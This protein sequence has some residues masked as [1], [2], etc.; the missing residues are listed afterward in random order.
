MVIIVAIP[1]YY[2][3]PSY[4][5]QCEKR[6][7]TTARYI[8]LTPASSETLTTRN[9]AIAKDVEAWGWR[10]YNTNRSLPKMERWFTKYEKAAKKSNWQD[11]IWKIWQRE[12]G[13]KIAE[14]DIKRKAVAAGDTSKVG[15]V[16]HSMKSV[17]EQCLG[18]NNMSFDYDE[19]R[20]RRTEA[21]KEENRRWKLADD[22]LKVRPMV[23]LPY[24][25]SD[26]EEVVEEESVSGELRGGSGGDAG[27]DAKTTSG[28]RN[29][30]FDS[31]V[32]PRHSW[33]Y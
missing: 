30:V 14:E 24:P 29:E 11:D 16:L 17:R 23:S 10:I 18:K 21:D 4:V 1:R 20:L 2:R 6:P 32:L 5:T 25:F 31:V 27:A 7:T 3:S 13:V 8:V 26:G 9:A 33:L 19:R 15:A 22:Q 12:H 28:E